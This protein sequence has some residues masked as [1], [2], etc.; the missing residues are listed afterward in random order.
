MKLNSLSQVTPALHSLGSA[1]STPRHR[2]RRSPWLA[3]LAGASLALASAIAGAAPAA[4]SFEN[5][6]LSVPTPPLGTTTAPFGNFTTD[7]FTFQSS[8]NHFHFTNGHPQSADSGSTWL[9][10]HDNFKPSK[11]LM[12]LTSASGAPFEL[13]SADFS[14]SWVSTLP[15]AVRN[16]TS[17][18]VLGF[19]VVGAP[20]SH[21]ILLDGINDG[22][23]GAADFQTE[24]FNWTNLRR[25][26]FRGFGGTESAWG[27]DQIK[28][29]PEPGSL[30]SVGAA[31]LVLGALRRRRQSS[32]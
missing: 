21:L 5:L 3:V 4:L 23:G 6:P 26:E 7:G 14:D 12:T 10:V 16:A 13:I 15:Q 11:N 29:V 2:Q 18:E 20:V 30:A 19:F 22:P 1:T 32:H 8:D 31:L 28:F 27:V 17:I 24:T 9:S 25:V